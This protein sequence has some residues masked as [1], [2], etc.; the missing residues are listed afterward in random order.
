MFLLASR[1]W[2]LKPEKGKTWVS[3]EHH[4]AILCGDGMP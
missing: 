3:Q 1:L 2:R 4:D